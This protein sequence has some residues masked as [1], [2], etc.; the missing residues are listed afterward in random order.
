MLFAYAYCYGSASERPELCLIP[1]KPDQ[2]SVIVRV[3]SLI[4]TAAAVIRLSPTEGI[5]VKFEDS[6]L[7]IEAVIPARI[8][9]TPSLPDRPGII[10][11]SVRVVRRDNS[12]VTYIKDETRD[13]QW[14][15]FKPN[16]SL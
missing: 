2:F 16:E 3:D 7:V 15:P 13:A 5:K 9:I 4:E 12:Y 10:V 1:D 14:K 6:A 8:F 11:K